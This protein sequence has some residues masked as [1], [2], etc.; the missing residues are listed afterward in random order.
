MTIIHHQLMDPCRY[1]SMNISQLEK[2]NMSYHAPV[3]THIL[4]NFYIFL[5]NKTLLSYII[6]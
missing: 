4:L 3:H 1:S 5:I 2:N 6:Q